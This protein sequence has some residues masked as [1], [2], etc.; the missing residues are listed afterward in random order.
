M[1]W[2]LLGALL[3]CGAP[4]RPPDDDG[5]SGRPQPAP[6][7][8]PR[9]PIEARRDAACDQLGPK[10]TACAVEDA[11]ANLAAGKI[12]RD[13]FERDTAPAIQHKNTEEFVRACKGTAYSSRQVRVLEVCFREETQCAPLLDCLEHLRDPGA[14]KDRGA[15]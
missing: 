14:A 4:Q 9:T 15:R 8:D 10:L 13:Q 3:A 7:T 2:L 12:G 11:R 1:K 6:V 5:R